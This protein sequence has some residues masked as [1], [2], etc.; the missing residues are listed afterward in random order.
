MTGNFAYFDNIDTTIQP[1]HVMASGALPPAL[2]MVRVGTDF[3]WDGGLVSNT[4]LHHLLDNAGSAD[5][6]VFQV[7]LF[8][9]RGPLPRDMGDVQ[10]RQKD[11]QYSSRTRLVGDMFLRLHRQKLAMRKLLAKLPD[12]ELSD[13]E[14]ARKAEL[15]DMS[16]LTILQM[17]YQQA[18]YEG[19]AKD[20]EFSASSMREHWESGYRDTASTLT[21]ET[22]LELPDEDVGIVFHD[23]HRG[24]D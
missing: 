17:I 8:S 3:Y 16:R 23:V 18:A 24:D 20:Y 4:P 9:A 7:D 22:W 21:N 15:A 2:P 6:L 5:M 19:Q 11:I 12:S 10:S 13:E 14:R 1:E